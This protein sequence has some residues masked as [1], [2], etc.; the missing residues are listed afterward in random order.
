VDLGVAAARLDLLADAAADVAVQQP[1]RHLVEGGL[2]GRGLGDDVDAV[3]VLVDHAGH[4]A[5]LALDAAQP[6]LELLLVHAVA[7]H[8]ASSPRMPHPGIV[9]HRYPGWVAGAGPGGGVAARAPERT[10][11]TRVDLPIE[12][13]TCGA[14][15][16]RIERGGS[17]REG[18][19]WGRG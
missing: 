4:A 5:D 14:C 10:G 18:V 15:A 11:T 8:G 2:D 3:L 7:G 19:G 1:Q 17:G 13:M 9:S 12:G 6:G 16:A